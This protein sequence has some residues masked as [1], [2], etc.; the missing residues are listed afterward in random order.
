MS[1]VHRVDADILDDG[2]ISSV[3]VTLK[4]FGLGCT[5]SLRFNEIGSALVL[6]QASLVVDGLCDGFADTQQGTY[7]WIR[8]GTGA[9][10]SIREDVNQRLAL[11][12]S[13]CV[14]ATF[15]SGVLA[16]TRD[17]NTRLLVDLSTVRL[18]G[19]APSTG[20]TTATCTCVDGQADRGDGSC[21]PAG[22]CLPGFHDGG[23]GPCVAVSRCRTGFRLDLDGICVD[24]F[25]AVAAGEAHTCGLRGDGIVVCW[26]ANDDGQ[27]SPPEDRFRSIS[28][29]GRHTCGINRDGA[30][31]CWGRSDDGRAAAPMRTD[32]AHISA[33]GQHTCAL[34]TAR[35]VLCWGSDGAGQ[36]SPPNQIQG[37][38]DAIASGPSYSCASS[39][40]LPPLIQC[41]GA[42]PPGIDGLQAA[43]PPLPAGCNDSG[44]QPGDSFL[45]AADE[46]GCFMQ[47]SRTRFGAIFLRGACSGSLQEA[48]IDFPEIA[49]F[50]P[51]M[52]SLSAGAAHTCVIKNAQAL[53]WGS[54][55]V[56]Q[57][58]P[59]F[60]SYLAVAA[61]GNHTCGVLTTGEVQ[62]WGGNASGESLPPGGCAP[63]SNRVDGACV[64]A[65][66]GDGFLD[67]AEICDAGSENSDTVG[68]ACRTDCSQPFCGDS[69]I[70]PSEQCDNGA[71][72][73]DT[74]AGSCRTNCRNP[75]C[76][77]GI[78]DPTEECDTGV[79]NSNTPDAC[80]VECFLPTCGD[81]IIDFNE[82]CDDATGNSDIIPGACRTSC[83]VPVCGNGII[84]GLEECDGGRSNSDTV[85]NSCRLACVRPSC[86]DDVVDIG[87][88]CDDGQSNTDGQL[89]AC[90]TDCS[91]RYPR[92]ELCNGIDDDLDQIID[93]SPTVTIGGASSGFSVI[94]GRVGAECVVGACGGVFRCGS[95]ANNQCA[96]PLTGTEYTSPEILP[97]CLG[98][99]G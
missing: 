41:W 62:C 3:D 6:S 37:A 96:D 25:D 60:G 4:R 49:P 42:L 5:L 67:F 97:I 16:F 44:C 14:D 93:D 88:K 27:S 99:N 24:K 50:P 72:N 17:V 89:G 69:I 39:N 40:T 30:I 2:C 87:E 53:C 90:A 33:G 66:C 91:G 9:T 45:S 55:S 52:S 75:F 28:A 29:G 56:G 98:T 21:A 34:T 61:G 85:A 76:G 65:E 59:R 83:E 64:V 51:N 68:G 12:P 77:D 18:A 26:G 79:S 82:E 73:S 94:S 43:I 46:F 70:D 32:F 1:S 86:G 58:T 8:Q 19:V 23:D 80:R 78:F 54:D 11:T 47:S 81:G 71:A 35:E 20:S 36:S 15:S 74:E 10:L 57:S 31:R 95:N 22:E 63:G 7:T 92:S 48:P 84:D 13:W 38:T